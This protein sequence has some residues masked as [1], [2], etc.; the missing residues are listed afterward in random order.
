MESAS[1]GSTAPPVITSRLD[2]IQNTQLALCTVSY[3]NEVERGKM[4][5]QNQVRPMKFMN[6]KIQPNRFKR[7]TDRS[8]SCWFYQ[9]QG[10]LFL[11]KSMGGIY[12]F[13]EP[14]FT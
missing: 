2:E 11:S 6:Q 5:G 13:F 9:V 14:P 1:R 3:E 12:N 7:G 10:A 4:P 8:C